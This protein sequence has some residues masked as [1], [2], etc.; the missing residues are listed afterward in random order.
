MNRD[1][2]NEYMKCA[3]DI[4]YFAETYVKAW[5]PVNGLQSIKLNDFQKEAIKEFKEKKLFAKIAERQKGKTFVASLLLLHDSLFNDNKTS[6]IVSTKLDM[7]NHILL[8]INEMY[9]NL[10]E[11][12]KITKKTINNR[13]ELEFENGSRVRS[14]GSNSNLMRGLTIS[15]VYFDESEWIPE[16]D[17]MIVAFYPCLAVS[18]GKMF[19]FTSSKTL[20]AFRETRV[21]A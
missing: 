5:H 14:I 9:D 20:E 10:P 7:G 1:E 8:R 17:K 11:F 12:L 15:N 21:A 4:E 6:I 3:N 18:G 19:A 16:V 2:I 13:R